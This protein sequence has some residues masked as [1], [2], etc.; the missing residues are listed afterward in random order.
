MALMALCLSTT[1]FGGANPLATL[2]LHAKSGSTFENCDGY[3]PVDCLGVRP[4]VDVPAGA[5]AA[6]FLLVNNHTAVAGVQ[7][8]FEWPG[9]N[10][11]FGLWEGCR[12]GQVNGTTPTAPGG[13][14]AGTIATAFNCVN[15]PAVFVV[16]RMFFF[17]GAGGCISQVQST[18]PGGN[19][20]LDCNNQTDSITDPLR[21]GRICTIG[22]GP[23]GHDACPPIVAVEPTTWGSIKAQYN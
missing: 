14:M 12:A 20:V 16:G 23:G 10:F 17:P 3:L 5:P 15:T 6:V 4:T 13:P 1:A 11:G 2:P 7:T 9:W 22:S 8:A 18:F 19:V 21:M